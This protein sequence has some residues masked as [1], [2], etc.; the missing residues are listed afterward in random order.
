MTCSSCQEKLPP[1]TRLCPNCG[2]L[3]YAGQL[4]KDRHP[5]GINGIIIYGA[6]SLVFG[7][8]IGFT[9]G[10]HLNFPYYFGGQEMMIL[11][12]VGF[13]SFCE[14]VEARKSSIWKKKLGV[15]WLG[16]FVAF[17]VGIILNYILN[18]LS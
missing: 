3:V 16:T 11:M 5:I 1:Q 8:Y 6:I 14:F 13:I 9:V 15:T 17:L 10:F 18:P 12:I 2:A 4:E 7:C